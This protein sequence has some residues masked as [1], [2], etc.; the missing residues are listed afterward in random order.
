MLFLSITF[1]LKVLILYLIPLLLSLRG[2]CINMEFC[3]PEEI[4]DGLVGENYQRTLVSLRVA[5][6]TSPAF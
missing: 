2:S 1:F 5:E 3:K 4:E 6:I